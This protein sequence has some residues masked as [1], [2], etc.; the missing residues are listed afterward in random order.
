MDTNDKS[1]EYERPS[2][3]VDSQGEPLAGSD[4]TVS[5]CGTILLMLIALCVLAL[6]T[7]VVRFFVR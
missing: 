1:G 3:P 4:K 7:I 6:G 2:N 5:T